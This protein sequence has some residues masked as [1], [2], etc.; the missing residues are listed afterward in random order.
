MKIC[1]Y[2][3]DNIIIIIIIII[4]IIIIIII[5]II[6]TNTVVVTVIVIIII[7]AIIVIFINVIFYYFIPIILSLV[8]M[9]YSGVWVLPFFPF[10]FLISFLFLKSSLLQIIDLNLIF[11]LLMQIS[12][13]IISI[14]I[15]IFI[16]ISLL[17]ALFVIRGKFRKPTRVA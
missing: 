9:R 11:A 17:S 8:F 3:I 4:V 12:F 15:I 10:F 6:I 16:F 14:Y 1:R 2:C 7:I 13:F 5:I